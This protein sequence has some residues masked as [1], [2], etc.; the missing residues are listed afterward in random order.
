MNCRFTCYLYWATS[1]SNKW[2][3]LHCV[4]PAP[5]GVSNGE[6]TLELNIPDDYYGVISD[7]GKGINF[8]P[9]NVPITNRAMIRVMQPTVR[10]PNGY[11]V[12]YNVGGQPINPLNAQTLTPEFWH[13]SIIQP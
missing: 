4:K 9:N 1:P 8:R 2:N 10:Y 6:T 11:V 13:F 3:G 12:F 7:N 5:L